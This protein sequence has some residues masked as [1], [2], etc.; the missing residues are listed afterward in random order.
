MDWNLAI[1]KNTHALAQIIAG[2]WKLVGMEP[3]SIGLHK[4]TTSS[5][6]ASS[7]PSFLCLS[8]ES[9]P[10]G[11]GHVLLH[12]DDRAAS[13]MDPR[14]EG[15]DDGVGKPRDDELFDSEDDSGEKTLR[16]S[17][18]KCDKHLCH[19]ANARSLD[20][21][22]EKNIS[23]IARR[24][25]VRTLRTVEAALRRLIVLYVYVHGVKAVVRKRQDKRDRPLPD[26]ASFGSGVGDR[27]P[28][29]R[30]FDPRKPLTLL[31]DWSKH[32]GNV[33]G[34]STLRQA[35]GEGFGLSSS[36]LSTSSSSSSDLFR[37]STRGSN[38]SAEEIIQRL[39]QL[40]GNTFN[41]NTNEAWVDSRDKPEDDGVRVDLL[42]NSKALIRRL[43]A[44]DH[45]LKTIPQQAKRLA[46]IMAQREHAPAGAYSSPAAGN[47]LRGS[48]PSHPIR[49]GIPPGSNKQSNEPSHEVLREIHGLVRDWEKDAWERRC[50]NLSVP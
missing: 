30:L 28:V 49:P 39:A 35:Q 8:Q 19:C 40:S 24:I 10:E 38:G 27:P 2:L 18:S 13:G 6:D 1:E 12:R 15:E 29:F 31:A 43:A 16:G 34:A 9:M 4:P 22:Q 44:L 45:A 46:R 37:G 36:D 20:S 11:V 7:N 41:N 5:S 14:H 50:E 26:F 33:Y 21:E 32:E 23:P 17:R 3:K 42:R 48:L 25:L 47:P